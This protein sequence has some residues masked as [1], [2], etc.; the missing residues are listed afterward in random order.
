MSR[1]VPRTF[2][3]VPGAALLLGGLAALGTGACTPDEHM[4]PATRPALRQVVTGEAARALGS[5]N[6]FVFAEPA[7]TSEPRQITRAEAEQFATA[8]LPQFGPMVKPALEQEHGDSLQLNALRRC[9]RT[10]YA[11]S[12]YLPPPAAVWKTPIG[13]VYLRAYGPQ[14][15]VPFCRS[16]GALAVLISVSAYSFDLRLENGKI[17][18]PRIGGSWFQ[19]RG[20]PQSQQ[21]ELRMGPEEAAVLGFELT[22]RR[23]T[24]APELIIPAYSDGFAFDGRWRLHLEAAATVTITGA[25]Q[26]RS[27][28]D[29]FVGWRPRRES[30][31]IEVA[32]SVQPEV[33]HFRYRTNPVI[34]RPEEPPIFADGVIER[35][36]EVPVAFDEVTR[37]AATEGD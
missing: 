10:L 16:S 23:I 4:A 31:L 19:W 6:E 32:A 12:A 34:G 5:S 11:R 24:K 9:H 37:L 25:R 26:T 33:I 30:K 35:N 17:V 3:F 14:W 7:L 21:G 18:M 27:T 2:P 22:G 15:L 29:L 8:F 13:A 28:P 1:G 36:P 20:V